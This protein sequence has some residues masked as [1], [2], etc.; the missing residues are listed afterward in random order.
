MAAEAVSEKKSYEGLVWL[1]AL[2]LPGLAMR[3]LGAESFIIDDWSQEFT[4]TAVRL[5]PSYLATCLLASALIVYATLKFFPKY[6][7]LAAAASTALT[8][9]VGLAQL[10]IVREAEAAL[11]RA[12]EANIAA[13]EI[14]QLRGVAREDIREEVR[15]QLR[16]VTARMYGKTIAA[17]LVPVL[18]FDEEKK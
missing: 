10:K 7:A 6:V 3:V 9:T 12:A 17:E 8:L 11:A 2:L 13:D 15:N 1:A 4:A 5:L 18:P 14:L 16:K